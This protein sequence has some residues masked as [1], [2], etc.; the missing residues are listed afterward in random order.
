MLPACISRTIGTSAANAASSASGG[1]SPSGAT[2]AAVKAR[3][4][5]AS[6]SAGVV[7][8]HHTEKYVTCPDDPA[9]K[10]TGENRGNLIECRIPKANSQQ[11]KVRPS[12]VT[13]EGMC[14]KT[15][16]M[17]LDDFL[18][19]SR[20]ED[21][22]YRSRC[23][24]PWSTVISWRGIP[25]ADVIRRADPLPPARCVEIMTLYDPSRLPDTI[26]W[27]YTDGLRMDEVLDPRSFLAT[28]SAARRCRIR[29]VR[30]LKPLVFVT[31]AL[32]AAW[33][34]FARV[35]D[36]PEGDL[37]KILEI[38]T[39]TFALRRLAYALAITSP[40]GIARRLGG[41]RWTRLHQLTHAVA[42]TTMTHDLWAVTKATVCSLVYLA[43]FAALL[44]VRG[45]AWQ[46]QREVAADERT[47]RLA[48]AHVHQDQ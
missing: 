3:P 21:R 25:L 18:T 31:L 24:E 15:A 4:P 47:G 41:A 44:G 40:T 6:P 43:L 9:E 5:V 22:T 1:L 11:C 33:L 42:I 35:T 20:V 32:P 14:P 26:D 37:V 10:S 2:S 48:E 39:G 8:R 12:T 19:P 36:R 13:I 46:K 7:T 17:L 28:A 16:T 29:T 38:D 30:A 45:V 27:P 34:V 23:V